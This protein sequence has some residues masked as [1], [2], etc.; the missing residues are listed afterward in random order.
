MEEPGF[1]LELR[2]SKGS[3]KYVFASNRGVK[4]P[5]KVLETEVALLNNL[6][7]DSTDSVLV[8]DSRLG[9]EGVVLADRARNGRVMITTSEAREALLSELNKRKNSPEA[10][11]EVMLT[12]D[13]SKDCLRKYDKVV[14]APREGDP[15]HLVK[16]KILEASQVLR[17]DGEMYISSGRDLNAE[18][19]KFIQKYGEV[20]E[21]IDGSRSVLKASKPSKETEDALEVSK[22]KHSIK[23]EE[24]R[25]QCVNGFFEGRDMRKVEMIVRELSA[26]KEDGDLLDKTSGPGVT[27]I[28]ADKLYGMNS[29][30]V[31]ESA[32]NRTY[33]EKNAKLND[34]D[35]E[36]FIDDGLTVFDL[37]SF[38]TVALDPGENI[39]IKEFQNMVEDCFR[40]LRPGGK[41]FI[42]HE[43]DF[44]LEK[45]V[46]KF[47]P[48]YS[49]CRRENDLQV[50][51]ATKNT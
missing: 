14:Y 28:F 44:P 43:K 8:L 20:S 24:V 17:E 33:A 34:V 2:P 36:A 45:T 10:S 7:V 48:T 25:F 31:S 46:R 51:S 6:S 19:K 5:E 11:C 12:S 29:S 18:L 22:L 41:V 35:L 50:V 40:I 4:R 37:N 26:G 47:F 42:I 49:L 15:V 21:I 16:Q 30:Y 13:V 3:K 23:G 39:S 9:V 32:Y 27:G 1:E 38:D